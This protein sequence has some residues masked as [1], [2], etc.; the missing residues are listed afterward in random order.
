[1][2]INSIPTVLIP[3]QQWACKSGNRGESVACTEQGMKSGITRSQLHVRVSHVWLKCFLEGETQWGVNMAQ[4][5]TVIKVAFR[6][7]AGILGSCPSNQPRRHASNEE[8]NGVKSQPNHD[9]S[10]Y[11]VNSGSPKL[12]ATPVRRRSSNSTQGWPVMGSAAS[13]QSGQRVG[14]KSIVI[15]AKPRILGGSGTV[16]VICLANERRVTSVI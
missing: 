8:V 12:V 13:N 2:L 9:D 15:S 3:T 11:N 1:M 4:C 6:A 10:S 5:H 7:C 14:N 16:F